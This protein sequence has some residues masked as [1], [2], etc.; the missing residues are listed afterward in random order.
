MGNE[1]K[2]SLIKL[3]TLV[4]SGLTFLSIAAYRHCSLGRPGGSS[5]HSIRVR[6]PR[7]RQGDRHRQPALRGGA[8][9]GEPEEH[10]AGGHTESHRLRLQS[11]R[12]PAAWELHVRQVRHGHHG[13]RRGGAPQ[14]R[15]QLREGHRRG[16]ESAG[17]FIRGGEEGDGAGAGGAEEG[18]GQPAVA[19]GSPQVI[20]D[21][22]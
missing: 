4:L 17:D 15:H 19:G 6:G 5:L 9:V 20:T 16:R 14:P 1:V 2:L 21:C 7:D 22:Q 13:H 12:G 11:R 8:E 3:N 18:G 10:G